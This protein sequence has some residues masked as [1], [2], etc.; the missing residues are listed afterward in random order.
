M[1][2]FNTIFTKETMEM[3]SCNIPLGKFCCTV[4]EYCYYCC[5]Y[6]SEQEYF[7]LQ[8]VPERKITTYCLIKNTYKRDKV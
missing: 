2:H 8:A 3:E 1:I 4:G 7:S 6:I 5:W